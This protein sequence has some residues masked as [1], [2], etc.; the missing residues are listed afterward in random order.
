MNRLIVV[1]AGPAGLSL[2]LQLA[3]AGQAV[4][5]IEANDGFSRQ[6]RGD[7]LMPCGLEALAHMGLWPLLEALPQRPLEGWSVWLERRQLFRVAEPMGSLQPCRLV[8]QGLLLEALLREARRQPA[9]Q[10]LPGQAV[11]ELLFGPGAGEQRRVQGV[12]LADG[13]RLE[14]DLVVACDGRSSPLRQM[15]ELPLR[16]SGRGLELLWFTLPAAPGIGPGHADP[17][18]PGFMTLLTGGAIGSAC[19]GAGGE[20]QLAWLLEPGERAPRR[21]PS[22]WAEALAQL[23][24]PALA[25]RIQRMAPQLSDPLRVRVQVGLAP[26]WSRPGLLLLGDA[27]HPMSPVRAQGIN[28]ALRDSLVAAQELLAATGPAQLDA[29]AEAVQRRRLPEIRRMQGLQ[30]AE[31]RQGALLGHSGLLRRGALAVAPL[32]APLAETLWRRRQRPLR[33]GLAGALQRTN[34][35]S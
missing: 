15:A 13:S 29:A 11:R 4:T 33:E 35:I 6:F 25:Q 28:M 2:A 8:P 31:A 30:S 7:A 10:W 18:V 23:A 21:G 20:L 16:S 17:A 26:R 19:R 27:A 1:G 12:Q 32:A 34:S 3:R 14:A 9:L 5:L 24:P 22:D